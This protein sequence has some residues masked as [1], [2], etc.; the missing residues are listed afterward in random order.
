MFVNE[1][2]LHNLKGFYLDMNVL[3]DANPRTL[4]VAG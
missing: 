2:Y 3:F 1:A 4:T